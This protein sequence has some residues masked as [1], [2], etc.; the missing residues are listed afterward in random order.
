[1]K[2]TFSFKY[3]K[4]SHCSIV[5]L[6]ILFES[7]QHRRWK[8]SIVVLKKWWQINSNKQFIPLFIRTTS[9]WNVDKNSYVSECNWYL[10]KNKNSKAYVMLFATRS[11]LQRNGTTTPRLTHHLT[12]KNLTTIRHMQ[13]PA[14]FSV[15]FPTDNLYSNIIS[16]HLN[17][18]HVCNYLLYLK[19]YI[20]IDN[21]YYII[22][23]IRE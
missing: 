23:F 3:K 17:I 19:R 11:T 1:M 7:Y 16:L 18:L 15:F 2:N 8:G 9:T 21:C 6:W 22:L 5:S 14:C 20:R 12:I 13:I 10:K 4:S